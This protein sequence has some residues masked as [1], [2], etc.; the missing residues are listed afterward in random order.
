MKYI[1]YIEYI[2]DC[3]KYKTK[4]INHTNESPLHNR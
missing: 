2:D 1:Q 3:K 4:L